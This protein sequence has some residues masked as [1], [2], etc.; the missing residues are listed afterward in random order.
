LF[1]QWRDD[2]GYR[3]QRVE[4][5]D[6]N[7]LLEYISRSSLALQQVI[8]YRNLVE[9]LVAKR[10]MYLVLPVAFYPCENILLRYVLD[11]C[12]SVILCVVLENDALDLVLCTS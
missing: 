4:V 2:L 10:V 5:D 11:L 12:G 8:A 3:I 6:K 1:L 9:R 7:L